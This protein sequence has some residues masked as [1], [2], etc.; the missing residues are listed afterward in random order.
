MS[1]FV[2]SIIFVQNAV[3]ALLQ[4][5]NASLMLGTTSWRDQFIEALQVQPGGKVRLNPNHSGVCMPLDIIPEY[6][7]I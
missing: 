1:G 6:N 4:R 7:A 3:D 2:I 5:T